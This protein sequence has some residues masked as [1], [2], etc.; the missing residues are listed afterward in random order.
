MSGSAATETKPKK[1]KAHPPSCIISKR[2]STQFSH[3]VAPIISESADQ[4]YAVCGNQINIYS[5]T[6]GIKTHTLRSKRQINEGASDKNIKG[7]VHKANIVLIHLQEDKLK[8][9]GKIKHAQMI[10]DHIIV[11]DSQQKTI[12][13]FDSFSKNLLN[14]YHEN[15]SQI[16]QVNGIALS[17]QYAAYIK[18][19]NLNII[20]LDDKSQQV[21]VIQRETLLREVAINEQGTIISLGDDY[22]KIYL[23][24]INSQKSKNSSTVIQTLHWHSNRVNSLVFIPSTPYLLSVGNEGVIVQWHL[25]TQ[26]K[27]FI[28]RIGN[29]IQS[30]SLSNPSQQYYSL[31]LKDNSLK[32]I[33]F[34]NNKTVVDVRNLSFESNKDVQVAGNNLILAQNGDLL[35]ND[36]VQGD[37]LQAQ[38]LKIKQRNYVSQDKNAN[39]IQTNVSSFCITPDQKNL[40]TFEELIDVDNQHKSIQI[41]ALKFWHRE[42]VTSDINDFQMIQLVHDPCLKQNQKIL[43]HAVNN[44]SIVA[45]NGSQIQVWNYEKDGKQWIIQDQFDYQELEAVQIL[46]EIKVR[47]SDSAKAKRCLVILHE[48][49]VLTY[50]DQDN[51]YRF[52]YSFRLNED[53]KKVVFESSHRFLA[54]L[55]VNGGVEVWKTKGEREKHWWDLNFASVSDISNNNQKENQFMISMNSE[56]DS[57]QMSNSILLFQYS[58]PQN[59]VMYWKSQ[60]P[61]IKFLACDVNPLS[62]ILIITK[63]Q[64]LQRVYL[65]ADKLQLKKV[66]QTRRLSIDIKIQETENK[67]Q[68]LKQAD[69]GF[70]QQKQDRRMSDVQERALLINYQ[71][72]QIQRLDQADKIISQSDFIG[73]PSLQFCFD[74][75]ISEMLPKPKNITSLIDLQ[76]ELQKIGQG[77]NNLQDRDEGHGGDYDM[78][79]NDLVA[80]NKNGDVV[81]AIGNGLSILFSSLLKND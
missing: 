73:M 43:L 20:D 36:L 55:S 77:L 65:G 46:S 81:D 12:K 18:G 76:E 33:R 21:K 79:D 38:V 14:T 22:G 42:Q 23:V 8:N 9:C 49:G 78:E 19:R 29:S 30:I 17:R 59:L 75:F 31:T 5:L 68:D 1:V 71:E 61:F 24:H 62:Y 28:S 58:R 60:L 80:Q 74:Q 13:L 64:E 45:S 56:D 50:W 69:Y 10:Q 3:K 54:S 25:E 67:L 44:T 41:Q 6:T 53:S 34:D 7:D 26:N 63:N 27:T 70:I 39:E 72:T 16:G 40:V 15:N 4:I 52:V 35:F 37:Q 32:V 11:Y 2:I 57:Q 51:Y 66:A 47:M 48:G